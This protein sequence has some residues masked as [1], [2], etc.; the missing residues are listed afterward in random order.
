MPKPPD[1]LLIYGFE[2]LLKLN[3]L[4]TASMLKRHRRRPAD[5]Q[6]PVA[7]YWSGHDYVRLYREADAVDMP[8]LSPGRQRLYD[9]ART[10]AECGKKSLIAFNKGRD[11]RRYCEPCQDPV[12]ERLW[13]E[14]RARDRPIIAE[15]ARGVLA[16]PTVVLG[17]CK[18][19]QY[20]QEVLVVDLD[21]QVLLQ[22]NVRYYRRGIEQGRLDELAAAGSIS[23]GDIVDQ[24]AALADRRVVCW[25]S[26]TDLHGL[27]TEFDEDG[28]GRPGPLATAGS[29]HLGPWYTRWVG[30][31]AG[32]SHRYHPQLA[33]QSPPFEPAEQIAR[34]RAV[35]TLMA[36]QPAADTP[37]PADTPDQPATP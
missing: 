34:M 6:E 20:W 9:Q 10:C 15:W 26:S 27:A 18:K 12:H 36:E 22:A 16:D 5:G 21:G 25:W 24:V 8:P 37:A 23:P 19:R 33:P 2:T 7:C 28:W 1:G 4:A 17:V 30:K 14:E 29:D 31:L 32:S 11:N 3:G 13:R 35:L